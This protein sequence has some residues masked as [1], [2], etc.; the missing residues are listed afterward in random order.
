MTATRL[1]LIE[2]HEARSAQAGESLKQIVASITLL[3]G[4]LS[5]PSGSFDEGAS[6][7]QCQSR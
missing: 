5:L 1:S 3:Y 6:E 4:P 2:D 7:C